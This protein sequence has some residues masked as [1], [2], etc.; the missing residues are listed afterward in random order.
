MESG[1]STFLTLGLVFD[2]PMRTQLDQELQKPTDVK[3]PKALYFATG[4]MFVLTVGLAVYFLLQTMS[5]TADIVSASR[6][7]VFTLNV[8]SFE[9]GQTATYR[10]DG[11]PVVVWRRDFEQKVQALEQLGANVSG[12]AD[13]LGEVR[14]TDAIE[15]EPD[16]VLHLDWF[17]VFP[18]N[19]GAYGC[20]VLSDAGDLGGFFDPCQRAH[21]DLWGRVQTGANGA[22]LQVPPWHI[23]E[24]SRVITVDIGNAPRPE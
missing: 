21:F 4:G 18:I 8:E 24:D 1:N 19:T 15:I 5:P 9:P 7:T 10:L 6:R 22:D 17:V 11:V 12:D 16:R 13:L 14:M 3:Q 23:S 20:V 2:T